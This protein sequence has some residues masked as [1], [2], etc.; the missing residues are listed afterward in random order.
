M[1]WWLVGAT[2]A[3]GVG[4]DRSSLYVVQDGGAVL[5]PVPPDF[6]KAFAQDRAASAVLRLDLKP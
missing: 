5:N 2:D 3:F 1:S 6:A 4:T